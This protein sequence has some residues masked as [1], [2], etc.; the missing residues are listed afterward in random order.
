M[1]EYRVT[2]PLLVFVP[3]IE[4]ETSPGVTEVVPTTLVLTAG[5][6]IGVDGSSFQYT[7]NGVERPLRFIVPA[8]ANSHDQCFLRLEEAGL[9]VDADI[10][11][12]R[13]P[14][15]A[16]LRFIETVRQSDILRIDLS[17]EFDQLMEAVEMLKDSAIDHDLDVGA[18]DISDDRTVGFHI[19]DGDGELLSVTYDTSDKSI[20]VSLSPDMRDAVEDEERIQTNP[21]DLAQLEEICGRMASALRTFAPAQMM[22]R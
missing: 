9:I 19:N 7:L 16:C 10:Q 20:R 22:A 1:R 4:M 5:E 18:W 6:M 2:K 3:S 14:A 17:P 11:S 13:K 8:D 12:S 21:A 15:S